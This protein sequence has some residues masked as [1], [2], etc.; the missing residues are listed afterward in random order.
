MKLIVEDILLLNHVQNLDSLMI[1]NLV[2][3]NVPK[4]LVKKKKLLEL[5][6][7]VMMVMYMK[8]D[9]L[10]YKRNQLLLLEIVLKI[11]K[12]IFELIIVNMNV[13]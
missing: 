8:I 12:E 4:R 5:Q 3:M 7:V 10:L 1:N 11:V 6:S 13:N 2:V 9:V